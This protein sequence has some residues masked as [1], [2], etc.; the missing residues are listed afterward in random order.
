MALP[1]IITNADIPNWCHPCFGK[2][3]R[4]ILSPRHPRRNSQC[5]PS[6]STWQSTL[7]RQDALRLPVDYV[8][9]NGSWIHM[10]RRC[11][12]WNRRISSQWP[13]YLFLCHSHQHYKWIP[14]SVSQMRRQTSKPCRVYQHGLSPTR[15]SSPILHPL[16]CP[17]SFDKVPARSYH[18]QCTMTTLCS[19]QQKHR[20]GQPWVEIWPRN[21][22]VWLSQVWL[23]PTSR[24]PM[25]IWITSSC[26]EHQMGQRAPRLTQQ[27]E[28]WTT[29][30]SQSKLHCRWCLYR[31]PPPTP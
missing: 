30:Q 13:W 4:R 31:D 5:S 24:N 18:R 16:L 25:W 23:W 26:I 7:G 3:Y 22:S 8:S 10:A 28:K 14:N 15:S 19:W 20:R 2:I 12:H 6:T 1:T 29:T 9:M 17:P 11:H 27:T 21:F